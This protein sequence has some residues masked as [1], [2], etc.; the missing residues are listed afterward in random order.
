MARAFVNRSLSKAKMNVSWK[1]VC[2]PSEAYCY[3]VG[4][5]IAE[6]SL[7][8]DTILNAICVE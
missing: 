4:S 1:W 8:S 6:H 2:N 3:S 5:A 7:Q